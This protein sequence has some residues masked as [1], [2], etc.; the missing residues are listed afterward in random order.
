LESAR[1]TLSAALVKRDDMQRTTKVVEVCLLVVL[2]CHL[3]QCVSD[4]GRIARMATIEWSVAM[5][6]MTDAMHFQL[7]TRTNISNKV[8][9][10]IMGMQFVL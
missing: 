1:T 2:V 7:P 3:L 8:H 9:S 6:C 10:S 5:E 4:D